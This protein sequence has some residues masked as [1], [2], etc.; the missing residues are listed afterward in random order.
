MSMLVRIADALRERDERSVQI[1][2]SGRPTLAQYVEDARAILTVMRG[3]TEAMLEAVRPVPAHWLGKGP[4]SD[5]QR[6]AILSTRVDV[7]SDWN[8]L[9]DAA[10][11][12]QIEQEPN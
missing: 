1:R 3:P 5:S 6:A 8:D 4:L 11:G 12:E 9:L 10:N 2:G 7:W